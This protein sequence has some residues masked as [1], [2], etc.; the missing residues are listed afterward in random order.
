MQKLTYSSD[1]E[2]VVR[3]DENGNGDDS[4]CRTATI[5]KSEATTSYKAGSKTPITVNAKPQPNCTPSADN[6]LR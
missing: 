4:R 1:N 5:I 2:G 3:V 6:R